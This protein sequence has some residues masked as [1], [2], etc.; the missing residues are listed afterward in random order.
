MP[1]SRPFVGHSLAAAKQRKKRKNERNVGRFF[2]V[3]LYTWSKTLPFRVFRSF[4]RESALFSKTSSQP[5]TKKFTQGNFV[6][7]L[8]LRKVILGPRSWKMNNNKMSTFY[9]KL[10]NHISS[11][12][13]FVNCYYP[14]L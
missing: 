4:L 5:E 11:G 9:A 14:L 12:M 1:F 10:K 8:I 13:D 7:F 3:Q 2:R 6:D